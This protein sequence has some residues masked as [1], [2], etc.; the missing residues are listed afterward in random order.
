MDPSVLVKGFVVVSSASLFLQSIPSQQP[1]LDGVGRVSLDAVLIAGVIALWK[2]YNKK[3]DQV[4]SVVKGF[5]ETMAVVASA[6]DRNTTAV[7]R[8]NDSM[9]DIEDSIKPRK[10]EH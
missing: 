1:L 6:I 3:D 7:T 9:E 10:K 5:T 4:M 8:M 2:A